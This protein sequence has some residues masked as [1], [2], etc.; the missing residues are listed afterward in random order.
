MQYIKA[1]LLAHTKE[2]RDDGSSV[3]IVAWELPQPL[4]PCR[5]RC[6][7]R[8]WFGAGGVGRIRY[9]NERAKG[10]HRHVGDSEMVYEFTSIEQLLDDF[11]RDVAQWG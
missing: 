8:L 11:E 7:Y 6:K 10:D 9:D 5:H 1:L 3:E 4:P 2:I